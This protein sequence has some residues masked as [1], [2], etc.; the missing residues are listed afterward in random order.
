MGAARLLHELDIAHGDIS[1]E[2][3][4]LSK[5]QDGTQ[6]VLLV[7]FGMSC[8]S[9][10]W[11]VQRT[12]GK[13]PYQAPEMH[14]CNRTE[15]YD[16]RTADVFSVGVSLYILAIQE[17]PWFAT[18]PGACEVFSYVK[19]KGLRQMMKS[20]RLHMSAKHVIDVVSEPLVELIEAMLELQPDS[21][22]AFSRM[23]FLEE[24]HWLR[25]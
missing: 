5:E 17:Y 22:H 20:K 24:A 10:C 13:R 4:L 12:R 19:K 21:R 15:G 25:M 16:G 14:I 6:R 18:K 2:N 9:P 1:L 3:I 8:Y 11:K 7:D 23:P